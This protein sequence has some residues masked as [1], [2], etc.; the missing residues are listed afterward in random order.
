[1]REKDKIN[2]SLLKLEKPQISES[3]NYIS[4]HVKPGSSS[5]YGT[6][7]EY[8]H[9]YIRSSNGETWNGAGN[10]RVRAIAKF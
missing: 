7:D 6:I 4:S 9:Y 10:Y 3:S 8:Y 1:M 5:S 2:E